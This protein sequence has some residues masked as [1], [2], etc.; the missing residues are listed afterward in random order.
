MNDE[1][2]IKPVRRGDEVL[3]QEVFDGMSNESRFHRFLQAMPVLTA[4]MR[5]LLADVDGD[6]HRAWSAHSGDQVVGVVRTIIDQTGE[7]E[8]SVSVVD[9][10]QRRGIGRRLVEV[11]L[12]DAAERGHEDV[13]VLIHPENRASVQLFRGIGASFRYEF[14]M[15]AGRV[16]CRVMEVAA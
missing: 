14:G 6:K 10:A 9:A 12:A 1:I 11:A 3:V 7:L 5:R 2:V 13:V 15:L 16:P 4:G 8:L